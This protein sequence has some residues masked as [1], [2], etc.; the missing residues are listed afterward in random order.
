[1]INQTMK[2]I[3][4]SLLVLCGMSAAWAKPVDNTRGQ[5]VNAETAKGIVIQNGKKTIQRR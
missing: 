4:F 3:L 5:R 1:M 2:K